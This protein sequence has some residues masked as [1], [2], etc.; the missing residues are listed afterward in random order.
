MQITTDFLLLMMGTIN[1]AI[2]TLYLREVRR[3]AKA[4]A[5]AYDAIWTEIHAGIRELRASVKDP[6]ASCPLKSEDGPCEH[7][8]ASH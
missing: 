1:V 3:R 7:H 2:V 6:C 4:S 5:V 8:A